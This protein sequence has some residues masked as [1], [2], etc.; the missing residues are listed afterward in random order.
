MNHSNDTIKNILHDNIILSSLSSSISDDV[1][2]ASLCSTVMKN[3][4]RDRKSV[5]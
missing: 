2:Y 5:V 3:A 4:N 1:K